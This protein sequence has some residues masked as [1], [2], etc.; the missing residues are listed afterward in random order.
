M[1]KIIAILFTAFILSFSANAQTFEEWFQQKK[2]Q[3]KYLV[4]QIAALK[5]YLGY[6]KKGYEIAQRGWTTAENIKGGN[7]NLDRDF[8]RSLKNVNPAIKNS[9]KVADIIAFQ[10]YIIKDFKR[11][12]SFCENNK[13]FS[14]E[15][16]R[17]I[18]KVHTNMLFLCDASISELLNIIQA[19][20]TE[21][22]DDERIIR[23][24]RIYE[25][26]SDKRAFVKSFGEDAKSLS[27][28]REKEVWEIEL[29]KKNNAI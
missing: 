11:I 12:Y 13:N 21:M 17:Y 4:Q 15:E 22:T 1:K 10:Y 16:I 18:A 25:D 8:F 9:A 2:T 20:K 23:I 6:V 19:D 3:K 24:N 27:M 5:V 14:P 26:M 29:L 7:F 28:E